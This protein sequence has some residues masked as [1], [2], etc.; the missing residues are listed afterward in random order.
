M[1]PK[2]GDV[3][4]RTVMGL[5]QFVFHKDFADLFVLGRV[6]QQGGLAAGADRIVHQEQRALD[7]RGRIAKAIKILAEVPEDLLLARRLGLPVVVALI[8]ENTGHVKAV[9][10]MTREPLDAYMGRAI[11]ADGGASANDT[12]LEARDA[13]RKDERVGVAAC[14]EGET[15]GCV[16]GAAPPRASSRASRVSHTSS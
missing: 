13:W 3:V 10:E 7:Q 15:G 14:D 16:A 5:Y 6:G 4:K 11:A 1:R 12:C 2:L 9:A 8:A